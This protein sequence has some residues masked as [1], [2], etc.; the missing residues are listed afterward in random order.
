MIVLIVFQNAAACNHEVY[1]S[2]KADHMAVAP[3][4]LI[5]RRCISE[6]ARMIEHVRIHPYRYHIFTTAT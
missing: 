2:R 6:S 1:I 3:S 5:A 4:G